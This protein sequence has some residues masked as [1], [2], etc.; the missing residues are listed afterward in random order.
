MPI[1]SV[2]LVDGFTKS[3]CVQ[4]I[5]GLVHYMVTCLTLI[6]LLHVRLCAGDVN[7]LMSCAHFLISECSCE[8]K[9][10]AQGLSA[11]EIGGDAE[12]AACLASCKYMKANFTRHERPEM[13]LFE[14]LALCQRTSEK[15]SA[16]PLDLASVFA[17]AVRIKRAVLGPE[18]TARSAC[19][20]C[21]G[22]Q[23]GGGPGALDITFVSI[24][25]RGFL[26]LCTLIDP[27]RT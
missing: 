9:Q 5:F 8:K 21:V 3:L 6:N 16:S 23:Q 14:S 7:F 13:Y 1:F 27:C 10:R 25:M 20:V 17:E 2:K 26:S 24:G 11:D 22:V 18:I 12:L 15:Q 19:N 4:A